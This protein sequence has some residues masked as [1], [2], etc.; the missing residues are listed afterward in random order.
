MVDPTRPD[1]RE[2]SRTAAPGI[3]SPAWSPH[4]ARSTDSQPPPSSAPDNPADGAAVA[5]QTLRY[6]ELLRTL[7][8]IG[9]TVDRLNGQLRS[10]LTQVGC[11]LAEDSLKGPPG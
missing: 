10:L 7:D 11:Q 4:A 6:V 5:R 1:L 9:E 3:A 8:A 2:S